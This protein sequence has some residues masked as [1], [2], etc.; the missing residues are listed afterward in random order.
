MPYWIS[1]WF[2]FSNP[3]PCFRWIILFSFLAS[4][5]LQ[6]WNFI[7]VQQ[8][9]LT[10]ANPHM[11]F[12]L[13]IKYMKS[14]IAQVPSGLITM[15]KY[16]VYIRIYSQFLPR[17]CLPYS[18]RNSTFQKIPLPLPLQYPLKYSWEFPGSI[19]IWVNKACVPLEIHFST[20]YLGFKRVGSEAKA[21]WVW[22]ASI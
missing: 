19:L 2:P 12:S 14:G 8:Y 13:N 21:T 22:N 17:C 4:S 1:I 6:N 10:S 18:S 11:L 15:W 7:H 20:R 16:G 3:D 5:L 9:W